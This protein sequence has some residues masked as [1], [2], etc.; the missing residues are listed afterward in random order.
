M[1]QLWGKK[2]IIYLDKIT[3]IKISV[4][5]F[6]KHMGAFPRPLEPL[7]ASWCPK[8]KNLATLSASSVCSCFDVRTSHQAAGGR[9]LPACPTLKRLIYEPNLLLMW[10]DQHTV[11]VKCKISSQHTTA[12][13]SNRRRGGKNVERKATRS[14]ALNRPVHEEILSQHHNLLCFY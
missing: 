5:S 8:G 14:G 6:S 1:H 13:R 11:L 2:E 10:S 12:G 9:R 3:E 4:F 7:G